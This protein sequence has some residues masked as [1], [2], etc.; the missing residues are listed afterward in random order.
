MSGGAAVAFELGLG[1]RAILS[2]GGRG[3]VV[4]VYRRAAYLRLP[5]GLFALTTT[6]V[7]S[8]PLHA[9]G[10][11]ALDRLR[12][13]DEA[14]V[15]GSV[16]RV[17]P[18]SVDLDGARTWRGEVLTP[19]ALR[20]GA[21]TALEVLA[22]APPSALT[23]PVFEPRLAQAAAALERAELAG[24]VEALAGVGPGLTPAGDDALAGILVV[25]R[26]AG[27]NAAEAS[28]VSLAARARTNDIAR[29]FLS[30]AARGQSVAPVH[31]VLAA[32]AGLDVATATVAL[33]RLLQYGH[34]SGADLALGLR[35]GV[36]VFVAPV[37]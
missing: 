36:C 17:G 26:A 24:V 30:W 14:V 28:L 18:I 23:D 13:G 33:G 21:T 3:T 11:A 12:R 7:P 35:L 6:D 1:A 19:A 22:G 34:S 29:A 37:A 32:A 2:S 25:A 4:A 15:A 9:R 10:C 16:L 5:G 20:R 8:G 27:G 31:A